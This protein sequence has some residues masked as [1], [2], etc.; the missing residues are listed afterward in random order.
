M[1]R[2]QITT[3]IIVCVHNESKLIR[4]CLTGLIVQDY[5]PSAFEIIVID[6]ESSDESYSIVEE[7]I[8]E[9]RSSSPVIKLYRIKH[10]GLSVAR[11]AGI[12]LSSGEYLVFIDGDAVPTRGWLSE[13]MRQFAEGADY[14]GGAIALLNEK[15]NLAR[16]LQ[17]TRHKQMFG[18]TL[19]NEHCIGCN[20]A[21]RREVFDEIGGFDRCFVSRGDE[22]SFLKRIPGKFVYR[23]AAS[24]VV[25]HERPESFTEAIRVNYKS[26]FLLP[27][28]MR[29]AGE[30]LTLKMVLSN[31]EQFL[32][33]GLVPAIFGA[34]AGSVWGLGVTC[35]AV[36]AVVRRSFFRPINRAIFKGLIEQYGKV[37]GLIIHLMYVIVFSIITSVGVLHGYISTRQKLVAD[38]ELKEAVVVAHFP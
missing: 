27:R 21:F 5:D 37:N 33:A 14:V 36:V 22:T 17:A 32:M 38:H 35:F 4:S 29:L 24:A 10:G 16:A 6:D 12:T 11:N 15:S 26:A 31:F 7:F 1:N 23:P 20:M 18:P 28:I 25:H 19:F 8:S 3:S 30:E 13:I 34:A 9:H 2:P